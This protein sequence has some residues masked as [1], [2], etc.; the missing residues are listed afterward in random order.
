MRKKY[1]FAKSRNN[2]YTAPSIKRLK[3]KL[4]KPARGNKQVIGLDTNALVRYL[5]QSPSNLAYMH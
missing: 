3:G 5:V 1:D 4:P 2:P